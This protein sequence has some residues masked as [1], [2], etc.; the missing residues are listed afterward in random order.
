MSSFLE[1]LNHIC[2]LSHQRKKEGNIHYR[3]IQK[4]NNCMYYYQSSGTV[5]RAVQ[6]HGT[7]RGSLHH[8]AE[9]SQHYSASP[10]SNTSSWHSAYLLW[11]TMS[12]SVS[13]SCSSLTIHP[14]SAITQTVLLGL[15][16]YSFWFL[17]RSSPSYS[18]LQHSYVCCPCLRQQKCK[19][20]KT[21][22]W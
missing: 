8:I 22:N 11:E 7:H 3:Y 13:T 1:S 5:L 18:I 20:T 6:L 19:Q 12:G 4:N 21:L 14:L 10:A 9:D 15:C 16:S 2:F 17:S